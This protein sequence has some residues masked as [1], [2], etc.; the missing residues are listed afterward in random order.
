MAVGGFPAPRGA[1]DLYDF[2]RADE[3]ARFVDSGVLPWWTEETYRLRFF[4]PL[5]SLVLFVEHRLVGSSLAMHV[6]SLAWWSASVLAAAWLFR[7]TLEQRAAW[8]ATMIFAL[9]PSRVPA[10]A[11]IAQREVL[12]ASTFG[13]LAI[14]V[15]ATYRA[16][17]YRLVASGGLFALSLAMGEYGLCFGG[18]ALAMAIEKRGAQPRIS[19]EPKQHALVRAR[20]AASFAA[21]AAAY[22][23]LRSALGYSASGTGFYRD[24]LTSPG[25]FAARAPFAFFTLVTDVWSTFEAN[26]LQWFWLAGATVAVGFVVHSARDCPRWLLYGSFIALV[27]VLG[28]APGQR[29]V[30]PAL[31]GV[32]AALGVVV[33]RA[34]TT[35]VVG[36]ILVAVV[37]VALHVV[38]GSIASYRASDESLRYARSQAM[39]TATL[40]KKNRADGIGVVAL[41][42]WETAFLSAVSPDE[43]GERMPWRVLVTARHALMLRRDARSIDVVVPKGQG[44]FPAGADD[45]FRSED[46]PLRTGDERDVPG[47]HVVVVNAGDG[48]PRIRFI[49]DRS[50]DDASFVWL[51]E[52]RGGYDEFTPPAE[53]FGLQLYP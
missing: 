33:D 43:R 23:A 51:S 47:M 22:L 30:G 38:H 14:A 50:L 44:F 34:I 29:L 19:I 49:F 42:S 8:I 5:A 24:P 13:T 32:A 27:P 6:I 10:L 41:A 31:L 36:S 7:K 16:S 11:M 39:R 40:V 53:H 15:L 21:P 37:V 18:Y 20:V 25:L 4:R 45:I 2:V 26:E 28:S 35:R 52:K 1:F 17:L 48:P 12:M 3:R 9:A 46:R